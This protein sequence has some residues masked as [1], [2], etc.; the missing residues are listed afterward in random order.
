MKRKVALAD[1]LE[2]VSVTDGNERNM[3]GLANKHTLSPAYHATVS[4]E[5][6]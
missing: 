6:L 3:D 4:T 5:D 1:Y 2:R